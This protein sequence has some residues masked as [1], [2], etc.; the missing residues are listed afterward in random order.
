MDKLTQAPKHIKLTG[1]MLAVAALFIG[2]LAV[3][4]ATG[5]AQAQSLDN[6]YD[7]P[8]PC[9]P[10]AATASMKE[11]HEV[12]TGR[13]ALFDAYW[14]AK[15][16]ST[17]DEPNEGVMHTN[18]CPPLMTQTTETRERKTVTVTTR[19]AS[20]I[21]TD[22][23][24]IHV[25]NKHR[26][27]VVKTNAEAT[28]GQLSLEEYTE[29][30]KALGLG[31]KDPVP[32][33]TQ[34]WW[35]RL[36]DP[37]TTG[38][39]EDETSDLGLGFSTALFDDEYWYRE[40]DDGNV[41]KPMRYMFEVERYPG[42]DPADVPHFLAYEAPKASNAKAKIVWNSTKVHYP[43]QQMLMDPG[44]YRALQWVFTK[45]GTYLLSVHLLGFVRQ[46][47]PYPEDD[48]KYAGWKRISN[49]DTETAEV[50]Q[51]VIQVENTL[52]E[53]EPPLFE[54][55]HS[56][57]ENSPA[58]TNVGK[59]PVS[60]RYEA[61]NSL[62]FSL[63]GEGAENFTVANENG[64]ARVNVASNAILDYET[65]PNF[66]LTLQVWDG[67]DHEG[68]EES[69]PKIDHIL[70]LGIDLTNVHEQPTVDI[71]ASDSNPKPGEEV[72]IRAILGDVFVFYPGTVTQTW[73][74]RDKGGAWT[75]LEFSGLTWSFTAQHEAGVTKE[76]DLTIT[77]DGPNSTTSLG[78]GPITVAWANPPSN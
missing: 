19:S 42:S 74:E 12:T 49:N 4:F 54:L 22:E 78:D 77:I 30:R 51:Y 67:Y 56:L 36:D 76:Y 18:Q 6:D 33:G 53:T 3:A 50:Q 20:N 26:V 35:L 15:H 2:L 45:P 24:I 52:D 1:A 11:P 63:D 29:V 48:P 16:R 60:V 7:D 23:A 66:D 46:E 75:N 38:T 17:G 41:V 55:R 34:V 31:K 72:T 70:G 10:G 65:G 13:F 57:K 71:R 47:N 39:D 21:D 44:E 5:P 25:L 37:D 69:D 9:G 64:A 59:H 73:R 32:S 28:G 8:Q 27:D 43:G 61:D 68:N 40:D 58:G 14:E 62:K